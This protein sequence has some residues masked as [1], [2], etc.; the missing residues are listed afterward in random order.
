[1]TLL[2]EQGCLERAETRARRHAE[3][4]IRELDVF[5]AG[6]ARRALASVPDL[7]ISRNR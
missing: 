4:A 6:P 7:L 1:M 3:L 5:P 2:R